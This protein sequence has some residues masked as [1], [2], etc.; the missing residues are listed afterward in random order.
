MFDLSTYEL[1]NGLFIPK[2][3]FGTASLDRERD[4]TDIIR[5]AL[6][7]GY[8]HLDTAQSYSTEKNV[9]QALIESGLKR[10]DVFITTKVH[11]H[12]VTYDLAK[13]SIEESL[14]ALQLDYIDLLL[15]HWPNPAAYRQADAWQESNQ[16]TWR[17]MV[18]MYH[19]GKVRSI[20]VS[21]FMIHHLESL[22]AG[23]DVLPTVNQVLLAPGCKQDELVQFCKAKNIQLEA[24]SPLGSGKIFSNEKA[25]AIADR[26]QRSIAQI[27]I[28]WSLQHE[29]LPIPRSSK[30]EH[31]KNNFEVF[32]FELSQ[33]DMDVLDQL[34]GVAEQAN[35]D[36]VGH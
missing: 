28:R 14:E 5:Y 26:H 12:H 36:T 24:Y 2:I 17:A 34:T 8:R 32:D 7:V 16:E 1:N 3:G 13:Q 31:I 25:Q 23:S 29:F 10:E 15:I 9:G 19:L 18:E 33:D 4:A 11:P 6:E 30:E 22:I 27:A 21:N 35:P 20:G